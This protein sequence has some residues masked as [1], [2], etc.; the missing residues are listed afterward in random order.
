MSGGFGS[1]N[2][3]SRVIDIAQERFLSDLHV[4]D[5]FILSEEDRLQSGDGEILITIDHRSGPADDGPE[6][7]SNAG[8]AVRAH[9]SGEIDVQNHGHEAGDDLG[10]GGRIGLAVVEKRRQEHWRDHPSRAGRTSIA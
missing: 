6:A 7:I 9:R 1:T 10:E 2:F 8:S 3:V 4:G 5:R